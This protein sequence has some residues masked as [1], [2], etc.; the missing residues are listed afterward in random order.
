MKTYDTWHQRHDYLPTHR[1]KDAYATL[2]LDGS[3][4]ETSVDGPVECVPGALV[5]HPSF[6]AHGNRFCH[7]GAHTINIALPPYTIVQTYQVWQ[8][9]VK[10]ALEVFRHMPGR[11]M[12]L[13]DTACPYEYEEVPAWCREFTKQLGLTTTSVSQLA[14]EFGLSSAYVS[15][16]IKR[17]YGMPP[18]VLRR[19]WR[20]RK[21]LS[22]I[23][24]GLAPAD[25][26][27]QAGF[28]DQ[29]HLTRICSQV[30][31]EPPTRLR[32][33]VKFVQDSTFEPAL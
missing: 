26:A 14:I 20:W 19:E 13:I 3:Y 29:S 6:H 2:V 16:M 25:I 18:V 32:Q 15:R 7:T 10:E 9:N 30:T 1:H 17:I 11:L 8:T 23:I 31:G 27:A 22:L 5:I 4:L 21:A 24:R 12:E 33:K 28:A